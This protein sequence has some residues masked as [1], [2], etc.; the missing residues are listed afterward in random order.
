MDRFIVKNIHGTFV[1]EMDDILYME[2]ALR[3]IKVHLE[4]SCVAEK[5]YDTD[6]ECIEFY[7][8]MQDAMNSL[9]TR[10]LYCHKSYIINMD[11]IVMMNDNTIR[12][13]DKADVYM[14]KDTFARASKAVVK[15]FEKSCK[16]RV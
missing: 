10:F 12:L 4:S 11:K 16:N 6:K 3:K 7:G 5:K 2:K 14:G 9:D 8:K 13:K 15:Y 1:L